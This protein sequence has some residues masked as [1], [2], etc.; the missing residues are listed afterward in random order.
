MLAH[1]LI[2]DRF[3]NIQLNLSTADLATAG[4]EPGTRVEVEIG[5]QRFYA[6]AAETFTDVRTGD[7]VLYED[8][9]GNVAIAINAGSAAEMLAARPGDSVA[10][11]VHPSPELHATSGFFGVRRRAD[12]S[13]T[14]ASVPYAR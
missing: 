10:I 13:K 14:P 11:T 3:G 5:L 4:I 6:V 12:R 2:V 8:A 1:V 7:V 9:Y